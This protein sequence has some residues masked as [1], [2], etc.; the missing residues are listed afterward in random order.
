MK[1]T[2]THKEL[3]ALVV[4][5]T[6]VVAMTAPSVAQKPFLERLRKVY[7]LEKEK[8]GS[9]KMCHVYDKDKGE[10]PEKD[11][12]GSFGKALQAAPDMKPLLKLGDEHKFTPEELD[13]VVAAAKTLENVDTDTDGATNLEEF[14]LGTMPGD[15]KSVPAKADLDKYRAEHKK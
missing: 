6:M 12:L 3:A 4:A 9:C 2:R 14:A 11:N 10:S 5:C 1:I 13:K 15:A 7:S 8:N